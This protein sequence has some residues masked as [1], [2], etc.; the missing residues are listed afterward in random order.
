M[1]KINATQ[2]AL[3]IMSLMNR[4][5]VAGGVGTAAMFHLVVNK[6]MREAGKSQENFDRIYSK[7]WWVVLDELPAGVAED[8]RKEM[9]I[10]ARR[11][12]GRHPLRGLVEGLGGLN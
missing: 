6:V 3:E 2:L 11:D 1:K 10:P 5:D 8:M 7:L 12:P 4:Y 9:C